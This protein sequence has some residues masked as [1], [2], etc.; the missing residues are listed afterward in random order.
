MTDDGDVTPAV[1][2]AALR[3][4]KRALRAFVAAT[5]PVIEARVR[6]GLARDRG[7]REGRDVRQEVSDMTQDVFA[8]LFA[9]DGRTL[10]AWE[11]GR[12][13]SLR[14]FVGLVA[15]RRVASLLRSGRTNPWRHVPE[16]LDQLEGAIEPDPGAEPRLASREALEL[17]LDGLRASL[18][19]RGLV[20]FQRLYVDE[21]PIAEVAASMGM[22][23]D[24]IYMWR[25]RAA[26][27]VRGLALETS[28]EPRT[29]EG[30][31]T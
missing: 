14:N 9:H 19:P 25:S 11:P 21:E 8:A 13:L 28:R 12:G 3:G 29:P 24:A 7:A 4:D 10:R 6:R 30:E 26:K 17:V 15:E 5:A 27:I 31:P 22:T 16:E 1:L 20:L 23:V 2:D 18:S